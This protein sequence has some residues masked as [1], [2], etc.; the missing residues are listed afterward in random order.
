MIAIGVGPGP[1]HNELVALATNPTGVFELA[2]A[3]VFH[4][5]QALIA[6]TVCS[7]PIVAGSTSG[8]GTDM[9]TTEVARAATLGGTKHAGQTVMQLNMVGRTAI[10]LKSD[11]P[12]EIFCSYTHDRP[13]AAIFDY[14][15]NITANQINTDLT[16]RFSK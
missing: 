5:I 15:L 16:I 11:Q 1:N 3:N 9:V 8:Q 12:I 2:A 7:A 10:R 14:K 4:D 13:S 6:N